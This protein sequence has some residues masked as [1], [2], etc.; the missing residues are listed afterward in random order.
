MVQVF[1][2]WES[3][4]A[5]HL[6]IT[7]SSLHHLVFCEFMYFLSLIG[8]IVLQITEERRHLQSHSE[9]DKDKI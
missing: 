8:I 4:G 1:E 2:K 3:L 6:I 9:L 7:G 5:S